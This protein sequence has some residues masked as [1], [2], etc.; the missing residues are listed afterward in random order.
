MAHLALRDKRIKPTVPK[1][2]V[3]PWPV[4]TKKDTDAVTRALTSG[5]IW[6]DG[7]QVEALASEWADYCGVKYCDPLSGGTQ[8]L[9]ACIMASGAGPG[10]EVILPAFSFHSTASAVLHQNAVPVFVDIDPATYTIDPSKAE[11]AINDRTRAIIA[12]HIWGLPADM[13]PLRRIAR[14]HKLLLIEDACQAHGA[15]YRG[16]KAGALAIARPSASTG[17]RTCPAERAG[18]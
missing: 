8:A 13:A 2:V 15:E 6:G 17:R 1:G 18:F 10:D 12:V 7:P 9:H 11:A 3:K 5:Q 14:K 16:K 4:V